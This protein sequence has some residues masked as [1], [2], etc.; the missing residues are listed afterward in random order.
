MTKEKENTNDNEAPQTTK[1]RGKA[2]FER[3]E[4]V[5]ETGN[6][7]FAIEMYIEGI[8]REPDNVERGHQPLR[9]VALKRKIQ[10]GKAAGMIEQLKRRPGK[11]PLQNLINAQYL[12][13]REPGA[14]GTMQQVLKAAAA[15]KLHD[16]IHWIASILLQ[17]QRQADK[18]DKR[19]LLAITQAFADI[20]DYVEAIAACEMA[21]KL[22]P[23]NGKLHQL[24]GDLSAKYAIKKGR[25]D[26]KGDFTKGVR[27]MDKQKDLMAADSLT[28][29]QAYLE[30]ELEKA[31]AEHLQSPTVTGKINALADALLK[32][33]DEKHENEA[34]ELL[35]EAHQQL[36]A[37]QFK[38]RVGNIRIQQMTRRYRQ[39]VK[40]GK[41]D[42]A[43]EQME[44]Q[45]AFELEEFAERVANYPTDLGIRFE[46]G[47]RQFIAGRYDDAISSLQE[48]Q[49]EPRRRLAA[50]DY[51]GQAFAKK[52]WAREAVDTFDKAL[53]SEV[54]EQ[55]AKDLRYNLGCALEQMGE[56]KRAQDEFS[57]VAQ[58][59]YNYK[60]VRQKLEDIREKFRQQGASKD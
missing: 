57:T 43:I 29:D 51:L 55:R 23:E 14:T 8:K 25:Y 37:Y 2:F 7:D 17:V 4:Q 44:R 6:W 59:D 36:G 9:E 18:P 15:L 19:V 12:L 58:L 34:T 27:D 3:A 31:R 56:S 42:E 24:L 13:S 10:G 1:G 22:D 50:M 33:G 39:Y 46:L 35:T 47:R 32:L 21:Q 41:K 38:M 52:G 53:Q 49:R 16:V 5:A 40:A 28:K 11:D 30:K 45:L 48:A 54:P 20:E 26:E 60:D